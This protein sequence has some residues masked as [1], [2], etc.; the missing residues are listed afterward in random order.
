M[1]TTTR[2]RVASA[3]VL[4]LTLGG[5]GS[6]AKAAAAEETAMETVKHLGSFEVIELRRYTIKPGGREDFARYF[7]S[8]FP[9]AFE[10]LGAL[11]LGQ[12]LERARADHFTWLRGFHDYDARAK[13]NAEFYFGPLWKEH[14]ATLNG[15]MLDSDDVLLL[16]P[17]RAETGVPVLPAVD[18]VRERDGAQGVV[19]AQIFRLAP[20]AM[21][22]FIARAEV[23]F[24]AYARAGARPAGVLVTLDA[25]NNF[26]QLP[27][28]TDGPYVVW[29]GLFPNSAA[30]EGRFA[31][32]AAA[33][34][35]SLAGTGW[36]Q[37]EPELVILDPAPRSRLRWR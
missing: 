16:R 7:E 4:S 30:I 5:F 13:V 26:P 17:L 36:L 33:L 24:E 19:V 10:Q 31:E 27:V 37:A 32:Q 12:F 8:Y 3:C 21:E 23:A 9:E 28:R 1:R 22:P 25:P 11:A 29:L 18:V 34:A 20:G 6:P 14:K 35:K 15:L 2:L